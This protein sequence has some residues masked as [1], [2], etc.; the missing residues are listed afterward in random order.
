MMRVNARLVEQDLFEENVRMHLNPVT[1]L[2]TPCPFPG[3]IDR[4]LVKIYNKI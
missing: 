3:D 1:L 4:R 2:R